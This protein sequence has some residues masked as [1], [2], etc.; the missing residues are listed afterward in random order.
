MRIG[1]PVVRSWAVLMHFKDSE[2]ALTLIQL[3]QFLCTCTINWV[4]VSPSGLC[5]ISTTC[6]IV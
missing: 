2:I 6:C 1:I 3:I 4:S 5:F